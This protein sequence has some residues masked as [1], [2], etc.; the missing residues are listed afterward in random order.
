MKKVMIGILILIPII[1][2]LVVVLVGAVISMDAYIE[3][4]SISIVDADGNAVKNLTVNA[5]EL[6]NGIFDILHFA[7][8]EVLPEKATNKQIQ[9]TLDELVV[10]DEEYRQNYK[11]YI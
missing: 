1:V 4:E 5:S 10:L 7:T 6:D 3:V 2:L 8:P 9:W 11:Y